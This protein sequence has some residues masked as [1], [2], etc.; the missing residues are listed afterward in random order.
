MHDTKEAILRTALGL[1]AREGY[2]AV[3]VS[4]ISGALGMT[5]S[6]LYK[7]YKNK[8][9]IFDSIVERMNE[10]DQE[11]ARAYE[12]PEGTL[13]QM[14]EAYERTPLETIERYTVAQ[15]SHWTEEEFSAQFRKLLTLEQY[16]S[17]EM[18]QLYQQYL[19]G[20][21]LQYMTDLFGR[22]R[23]STGDPR[24]LALS[25]YGPIVLL[26]SLYDGAEEKSAVFDLLHGHIARF[27]DEMSRQS[28]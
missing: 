3:S 18:A 10:M 21:P 17:R 23:D 28:Q 27:V 13:E 14:A 22:M 6:A 16:R 15:F 19:V 25:F 7:H 11:R 8:R 4:Q 24:Q 12:M 2:E 9:A 20:G 1:F 26:Y 5:K